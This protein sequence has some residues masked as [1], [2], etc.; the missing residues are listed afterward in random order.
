MNEFT[1]KNSIFK[2]HDVN[3]KLKE[4]SIIID[5][6]DIEILVGCYNAF[7]LNVSISSLVYSEDFGIFGTTI[8]TDLHIIFLTQNAKDETNKKIER[9]CSIFEKRSDLRRCLYKYFYAVMTEEDYHYM[10]DHSL[11]EAK[12]FYKS[13]LVEYLAHALLKNNFNKHYPRLRLP[14]N[15]ETYVS[16]KDFERSK[17]IMA[18]RFVNMKRWNK[19]NA[20]NATLSV[21]IDDIVTVRNRPYAFEMY[22]AITSNVYYSNS[23]F[24]KSIPIG[25]TI[26][27][28]SQT[29]MKRFNANAKMKSDLLLTRPDLSNYIFAVMSDDDFA[30]I[31]DHSLDEAKEFYK[32]KFMEWIKSAFIDHKFDEHF[33]KLGLPNKYETLIT[34]KNSELMNEIMVN[35]FMRMKKQ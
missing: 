32:P 6:N 17:E 21:D 3:G 7:K 27:F 12:E 20:T 11:D 22:G 23:V 25:L 28:I 16:F 31:D 1:N 34:I 29:W 33:P 18:N 8:D 26:M 5:I 2:I 35:Q 15:Y 13:K 10:D 19:I 24:T 4:S 9:N 30:Y 14:E